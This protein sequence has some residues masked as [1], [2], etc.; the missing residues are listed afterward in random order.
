VNRLVNCW[1]V[2]CMMGCQ[3]SKVEIRSNPVG[4]QVEIYNPKTNVYEVAGNTPFEI[5]E[6]A[7]QIPLS[8]LSSNLV[9]IRISQEGFI[10]EQILLEKSGRPQIKIHANLIPT[11]VKEIV[12]IADDNN[13]HEI[14]NTTAQKLN[15]LQELIAANKIDDGLRIIGDML[16]QYPLSYYLWDIKGS[17][18]LS[19]GDN[20][21]ARKSYEKSIE[22]NPNNLDT[23]ILLKKIGG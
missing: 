6:S 8:I 14:V 10:P 9:T 12:K 21:R 7:L 17:L 11:E 1:F 22:L 15:E 2:I 4:A 5:S 3:T 13:N 23:K 18:L 20:A 19:K 16:Q